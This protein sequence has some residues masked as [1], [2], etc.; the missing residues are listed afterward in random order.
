MQVAK[1]RFADAPL[2]R[3]SAVGW[4]AELPDLR[5]Q[6]ELG[7]EK[8]EAFYRAVSLRFSEWAQKKTRHQSLNGWFGAPGYPTSSPPQTAGST[9]VRVCENVQRWPPGSTA[10]YWRSPYG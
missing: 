3:K 8:R 9:S 1:L 2:A 5:P 10:T 7:N 6:A 4:E